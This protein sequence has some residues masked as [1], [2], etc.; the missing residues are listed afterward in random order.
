MTPIILLEDTIA[1]L[2]Q[3]HRLPLD[4]IP[5]PIFYYQLE[6]TFVMDRTL[7]AQALA[8]APNLSSSGLFKMVYEHLFRCFILEDHLQG[9]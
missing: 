1:T 6:H 3:L 4:L 9:F 2:R 8:I 5:P 7:F